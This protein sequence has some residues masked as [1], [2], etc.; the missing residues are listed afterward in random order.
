MKFK[1]IELLNWGPYQNMPPIMLETSDKSP[2]TIIYGNNGR[3][4][5]SLF[6]AIFYVLYGEQ[7]DKFSAARYANW[8]KVLEGKEFPVKITLIYESQGKEIKLSRGFS[9]I[10]VNK[11]T[12]EVTV[13][14][15]YQSMII[16]NGQPINEK[17]IDSFIRRDLPQEIAKFFLFDGEELEKVLKGL[18]SNQSTARLPIKD[19]I[20]SLLGI[21]SLKYLSSEIEKM[22]DNLEKEIKS[23]DKNYEADLDNEEKSKRIDSDIEGIEKDLKQMA[24]KSTELLAA[25]ETLMLELERFETAQQDIGQLRTLKAEELRIATEIDSGEQQLRGYLSNAWFL[26]IS[27]IVE[28]K[29]ESIIENLI[30]LNEFQQ[31]NFTLNA[32]INE[33]KLRLTTSKCSSCG[34]EIEVNTTLINAEIAQLEKDLAKNSQEKNASRPSLSSGTWRD[35]EKQSQKLMPIVLESDKGIRRNKFGLATVRSNMLVIENRL[36]QV[37]QF[38]LQEKI[39]K[40]EIN[41][42]TINDLK[43]NIDNQTE[44]LNV[45]KKEKQ[46][47]RAKI[48]GAKGVNPA[49]RVKLK[50]LE[51]LQGIIEDS[52]V[53]FSNSIRLRVEKKASE[54]FVHIMK[55]DDIIGLEISE[56]YQVWIKH[57]TLGRKP[58]GSFGQNLVFVYALIGALIDV[59][60]NGSSWVID[61]PIAKLDEIRAPSVWRWIS[62]RKRQIIVLPHKNELTPENAKILMAGMVGREYEI[63]PIGED[64][65]S[66]IK[67]LIDLKG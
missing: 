2:I 30:L 47:I 39:T 31:T 63:T 13:G 43:N 20:E 27:K 32:R 12:K 44:N 38:D 55:N 21:P 24:E 26:P 35:L 66:E 48:V 16:D 65:W 56:D 5:T 58:A 54:H 52:I 11:E 7:P 50:Y 57:K 18:S 53:K 51:Q 33:L 62:Q 19:G 46:K 37:N 42:N 59:S 40:R 9:A 1:S 15:A 29:N 60:G 67:P 14:D 45:K 25:N 23:G 28:S 34:T 41:N 4:K 17:S 61:S 36:K 64:A 22:S 8:F 10:P 3:G 49:F 6:N